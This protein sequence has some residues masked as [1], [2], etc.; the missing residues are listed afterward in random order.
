MIIKEE[1]EN[2]LAPLLD[3]K[4]IEG[5]LLLIYIGGTRLKYKGT[6]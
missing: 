6:E 4:T 1:T 5:G 3:Q 2:I